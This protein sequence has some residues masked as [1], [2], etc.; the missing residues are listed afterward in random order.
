METIE[1][2]PDFPKSLSKRAL[3]ENPVFPEKPIDLEPYLD[4]LDEIGA[5]DISKKKRTFY[6]AE[7]EL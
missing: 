5:F 6:D 2:E 1:L 3:D 7:F 4:F